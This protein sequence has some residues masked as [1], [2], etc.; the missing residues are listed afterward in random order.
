MLESREKQ[1]PQGLKPISLRVT[2]AW[3]RPCLPEQH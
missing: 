3:L 1:E 2:T